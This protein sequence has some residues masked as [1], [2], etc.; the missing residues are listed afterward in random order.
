MLLRL[1]T[2]FHFFKNTVLP[3]AINKNRVPLLFFL[4]VVVVVLGLELRALHLL[5]SFSST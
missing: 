4:V 2:F 5:G 3:C 1:G